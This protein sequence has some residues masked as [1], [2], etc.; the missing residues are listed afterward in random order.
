MRE[1]YYLPP[2]QYM[3]IFPKMLFDTKLSCIQDKEFQGIQ[4]KLLTVHK[5]HRRMVTVFLKMWQT[6]GSCD[7]A[8]DSFTP[9]PTHHEDPDHGPLPEYTIPNLGAY[10]QSEEGEEKVAEN[11]EIRV[12][13]DSMVADDGGK[14]A[15]LLAHE[16][17]TLRKHRSYMESM[18]NKLISNKQADFVQAQLG[19]RL[20]ATYKEL[21]MDCL[22]LMGQEDLSIKA[23][24]EFGLLEHLT[25]KFKQVLKNAG[26]TL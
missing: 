24:R 21:M 1:K 6:L 26:K 3:K 23:A 5:D 8:I 11:R 18:I 16:I 22:T 14:N 12:I 4:D 20:H 17:Y 15:K 2:A 10:L 19:N 25:D 7:E 13:R 9:T